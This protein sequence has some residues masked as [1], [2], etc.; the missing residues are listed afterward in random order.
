MGIASDFLNTNSEISETQ[1][2]VILGDWD[3]HR[4]KGVKNKNVTLTITEKP[5]TDIHSWKTQS[6]LM[7]T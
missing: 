7:T 1:K 5:Q 2:Q 6:R 4:K 3:W